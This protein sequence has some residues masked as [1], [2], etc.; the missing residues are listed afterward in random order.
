MSLFL[1]LSIYVY[2]NL[3][4]HRMQSHTMRRSE[5][6]GA[7]NTYIDLISQMQNPCYAQSKDVF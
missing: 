4:S 7:V 1:A 5:F 6:T 3:R 2:R